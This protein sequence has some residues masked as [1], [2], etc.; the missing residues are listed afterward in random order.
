M[1]SGT[2]RG[3]RAGG[4]FSSLSGMFSGM[5]PDAF[6]TASKIQIAPASLG[7]GYAIFFIYSCLIGVLAII[8]T[9]I[10]SRRQPA[11]AAAADSER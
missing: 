2:S 11:T 5:T 1:A 10:I 9:L 8:L 3:G 7:V 4:M 6:V